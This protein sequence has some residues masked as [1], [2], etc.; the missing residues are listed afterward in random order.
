MVGFGRMDAVAVPGSAVTLAVSGGHKVE[1]SHV[2][3]SVFSLLFQTCDMDGDGVVGGDAAAVFFRRSGLPEPT[4]KEIWALA[5]GGQPV[6]SLSLEAWFVACKL[7][8]LAQGGHDCMLQALSAAGTALPL[9]DFDLSSPALPLPPPA[10][11]ASPRLA[12]Q[13]AAG[14][15]REEELTVTIEGHATAGE[16]YTSYTAFRLRTHTTMARYARRDVAVSRRFRDFQWLHGCFSRIGGTLLPPL[17]EKRIIGNANETFIAERTKWLERYIARVTRHPLLRPSF[18]LQV[19]LTASPQGLA[20]AKALL[21]WGSRSAAAAVDCPSSLVPRLPSGCSPVHSTSGGNGGCGG[22][23]CGGG[24]S[25]NGRDDS[26]TCSRSSGGYGSDCSS[27]GGRR[28]GSSGGSPPLYSCSP[29]ATGLGE[30]PPPMRLPGRAAADTGTGHGFGGSDSGSGSAAA[31]PLSSMRPNSA[32]EMV[33][34]PAHTWSTSARSYAGSLWGS[35]KTT[36]GLTK[37]TAPLAIPQDAEYEAAAGRLGAYEPHLR[38]AADTADRLA[39]DKRGQAY[40]LSRLGHYLQQGSMLEESSAAPEARM[41]YAVG[42]RTEDIGMKWLDAIDTEVWEFVDVVE[43]HSRIVCTSLPGVVQQRKNTI[44]ELQAA[45][46]SLQRNKQRLQAAR[47]SGSRPTAEVAQG[48]MG[49]A[50]ARMDDARARMHA[51]SGTFKAEAHRYEREKTAELQGA[52][53]RFV[54]LQAEQAKSTNA[55]W[56]RVLEDINP[57]DAEM[58]ASL[59]RV[60]AGRSAAAAAAEA[61]VGITL[62]AGGGGGRAAALDEVDGGGEGVGLWYAGDGDDGGCG[63]GNSGSGSAPWRG[64]V[65]GMRNGG[66]QASATDLRKSGAVKPLSKAGS[67][68]HAAAPAAKGMSVSGEIMDRDDGCVDPC[69]GGCGTT[70]NGRGGGGQF[71]AGHGGYGSNGSRDVGVAATVGAARNSG[72]AFAVGEGSGDGGA[73]GGGGDSSSGDSQGGGSSFVN[74]MYSERE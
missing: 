43:E 47:A 9:P 69:M 66:I 45:N 57:T 6:A 38:H 67:G 2:E 31:A 62:I 14:D 10:P 28:S 59:R 33:S 50:E 49:Q 7:C 1:F 51:I 8:A 74:F 21:P 29:S 55:L 3:T 65:D 68:R 34:V 23:D 71:V 17:P 13:K 73:G 24:G 27:G 20:A 5:C 46:G 30:T 52:L 39:A 25:G 53:L 41:L 35:V 72:G 40:E 56:K 44:L 63:G 61:A 22:G 15:G 4:L 18:E 16:G 42:W 64:D 37:A 19:F 70:Q 11:P 32:S 48:K 26:S 60:R 58:Q 12:T 54:E 36:V